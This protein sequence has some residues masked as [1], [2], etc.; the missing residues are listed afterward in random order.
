MPTMDAFQHHQEH[1][2]MPKVTQVPEQVYPISTELQ[3]D[4]CK[5]DISVGEQQMRYLAPKHLPGVTHSWF[6]I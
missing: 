2:E 1:A 5:Q 6:L 4:L 3:G